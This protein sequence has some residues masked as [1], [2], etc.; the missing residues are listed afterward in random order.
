MNEEINRAE[1]ISEVLRLEQ[2]RY[3]KTSGVI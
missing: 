1:E 2:K 3:D